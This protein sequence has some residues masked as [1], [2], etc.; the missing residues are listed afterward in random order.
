MMRRAAVNLRQGGATAGVRDLPGDRRTLERYGN[1][2]RLF[3]ANSNGKAKRP[4]SSVNPVA[5]IFTMQRKATRRTYRRSG[6]DGK[7]SAGEGWLVS[8]G[9]KR[10][11]I[12]C[13]GVLKHSG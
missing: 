9:C 7:Y 11:R 8:A 1:T 2:V 6:G 12:G 4:V 5:G 3:L 13:K 10:W